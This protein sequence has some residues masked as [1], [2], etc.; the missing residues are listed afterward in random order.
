MRLLLRSVKNKMMMLGRPKQCSTIDFQK[1]DV[2]M[3]KHKHHATREYQN[4]EEPLDHI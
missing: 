1:H 2:W 4:E 3:Q